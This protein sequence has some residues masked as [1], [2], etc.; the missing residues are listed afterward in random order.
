MACGIHLF[1]SRTEKLS[2]TTPMVLRKSG[3]VGSRLFLKDPE[4]PVG[5]SGF[6]FCGYNGRRVF[7]YNTDLREDRG[8]KSIKF[9]I[10]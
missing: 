9:F 8:G 4:F 5:S 2:H 10:S 6:F 1:P 7:L 3:R